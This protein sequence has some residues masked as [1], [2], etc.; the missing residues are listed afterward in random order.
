MNENGGVWRFVGIVES[1]QGKLADV[2]LGKLATHQAVS[3]IPSDDGD[4]AILSDLQRQ[5]SLSKVEAD[6]LQVC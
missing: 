3:Y 4:V 6:T 1:S 2:L 5:L